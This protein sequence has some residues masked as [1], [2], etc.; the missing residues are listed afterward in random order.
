MADRIHLLAPTVSWPQAVRSLS[1]VWLLLAAPLPAP[2]ASEVYVPR[3]HLVNVE[4]A[5]VTQGISPVPGAGVRA[6]RDPENETGGTDRFEIQW[7]ANPP[8]IPP[9]VV[10]LLESLQERSAV[11]KNH[12]LRTT[13]KSEGHIRSIIEIPSDE[14]RLAGRVL[15]WRVRVVWRGRPLASQ[16]SDNWDG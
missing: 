2:A 1:L 10:V 4:R 15:K 13:G 11:V 16:T 5:F 9:G 12:I 14:I 8:G 7:Y 6:F 3:A